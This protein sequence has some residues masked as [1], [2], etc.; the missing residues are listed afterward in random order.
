MVNFRLCLI[1][2]HFYK[3]YKQEEVGP[4]HERD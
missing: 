3:N 2:A 4:L 1:G